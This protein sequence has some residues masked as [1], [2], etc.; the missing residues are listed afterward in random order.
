M[1]QRAAQDAFVKAAMPEIERAIARLIGRV[2]PPLLFKDFI[3][4]VS[5][6]VKRTAPASNPICAEGLKSA[7]SPH[8]EKSRPRPLG[9]EGR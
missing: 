3:V 4:E 5:V 6:S 8:V 7:C 2:L 1:D 9:V